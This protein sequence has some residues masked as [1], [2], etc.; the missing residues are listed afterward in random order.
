MAVVPIP[1]NFAQRVRPVEVV[2]VVVAAAVVAANPDNEP[3]TGVAD[4]LA[5][6]EGPRENPVL[7]VVAPAPPN[8]SPPPRVSPLAVVTVGVVPRV[9]LLAAEVPP[10]VNPAGAEAEE[11]AAV[12]PPSVNP[13]VGFAVVGTVVLTAPS[14]RPC[15]GVDPKVNPTAWVLGVLNVEPKSPPGWVV[16]PPKVKPVLGCPVVAGGLPSVRPPLNGEGAAKLAAAGVS[17]PGAAAV[18]AGAGLPK[19]KPC[20]PN[21]KKRRIT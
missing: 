13:G 20:A 18:V 11:P 14:V 21:I 16:A 7:V 12:P 5:A 10:R 19:L 4:V 2:L 1:G 15:D 6:A 9:I 3:K 17:P 8:L